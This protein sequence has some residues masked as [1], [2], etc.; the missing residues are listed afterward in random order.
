MTVTGSELGDGDRFADWFQQVVG[1]HPAVKVARSVAHVA[2][3][4]R[5]NYGKAQCR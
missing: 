1:I 5:R 2:A 4:R 3:S